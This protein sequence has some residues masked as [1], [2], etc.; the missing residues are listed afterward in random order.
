MEKENKRIF[1]K[2]IE[3]KTMLKRYGCSLLFPIAHLKQQHKIKMSNIGICFKVNAK[4]RL[5]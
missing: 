5:P 3:T 4:F 1:R 2:L